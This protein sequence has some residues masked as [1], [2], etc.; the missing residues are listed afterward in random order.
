MLALDN[1]RHVGTVLGVRASVED[2]VAFAQGKIDFAAFKQKAQTHRYPGIG[3]KLTSV[4]SWALPSRSGA[5]TVAPSREPTV[6]RR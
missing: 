2:V 6:D 5:R 1:V 3:Y 4:N